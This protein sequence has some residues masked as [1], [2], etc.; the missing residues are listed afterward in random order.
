[1]IV[2]IMHKFKMPEMTLKSKFSYLAF[3]MLRPRSKANCRFRPN[4]KSEAQFLSMPT[5]GTRVYN[6]LFHFLLIYNI[7]Q[8]FL[9]Y[10]F[11]FFTN[12]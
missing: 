4:I 6:L 10:L 11:T 7:S 1:M 3:Q 12:P 8:K 2:F 9:K 5:E